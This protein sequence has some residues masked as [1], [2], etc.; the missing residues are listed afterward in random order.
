MHVLDVTPYFS[1]IASFLSPVRSAGR[2]SPVDFASATTSLVRRLSR[3]NEELVS[4]GGE[5]ADQQQQ[6]PYNLAEREANVSIASLSPFAKI[7]KSFQV[8]NAHCI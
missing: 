6:E 4:I 3:S 8:L 2:V 7:T 5:G 1:V